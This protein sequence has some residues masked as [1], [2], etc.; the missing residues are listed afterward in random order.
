MEKIQIYVSPTGNDAAAGT[1]EAP[2]ATLT[3]ARNY[4]RKQNCTG[5]ATVTFLEG[6]YSFRETVNFST[7]D[8]GNSENPIVY[9]G[10]GNVIFSGGASISHDHLGEVT[11]AAMA[12]RMPEPEKVKALDLRSLGLDPEK[13]MGAVENTPR[14]YVGKNIADKAYIPARFPNWERVGGRKGPYLSCEKITGFEKEPGAGKDQMRL[15]FHFDD[16]DTARPKLEKWTES[17]LTDAYIY[18]YF[19]HQWVYNRYIPL[20]GDIGEGTLTAA[21]HAD[22]KEVPHSNCYEKLGETTGHRRRLFVSNLPEELDDAG[23]YYYDR[24][25]RIL[26]F[27][28]LDDFTAETEMT[29]SVYDKP[30]VWVQGAENITFRNIRFSY[31]VRHPLQVSESKSIVFDGCEI[32][33]SSGRAAYVEK[34]SDCKFISCDIFDHTTGGILFQSCGDRYNLV[35]SGN[36]VRNCIIQYISEIVPLYKPSVQCID[37]CG[38]TIKGNTI[39]GHAHALII[40]TGVNDIL[41][42]DNLFEEA[43]KDVDDASAVY[44]GRDP[45]DLGI[46][47]RNNFFRNIGNKEATYALSSIYIDDM[48]TGGEIYNNVFYNAAFISDEKMDFLTCPYAMMLNKTQFN[49]AYNNIVVNTYPD[50]KP[51]NLFGEPSFVHWMTSLYDI[52]KSQDVSYDLRGPWYDVLKSQGFL[53]PTWREH[54]RNTHWAGMWDYVNEDIYQR[55]EDYRNAYGPENREKANIDIMWAIYNEMWDHHTEEGEYYSGTFKEYYKER[56][57]EDL[58]DKM[59]DFET[60]LPTDSASTGSHI[61]WKMVYHKLFMRSSNILENNITVGMSRDYLN[62]DGT[63]KGK[64]MNGFRKNYHPVTDKL[65]NGESM[66]VKFGE[67]FDLTVDGL[68]EI[69]KHIPEFHNFSVKNA[70]A[71]R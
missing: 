55:I 57:H 61:F 52:E 49:K 30:G 33:H 66:F 31:F 48:A 26:Y 44:W 18:G 14:F 4:L 53:T 42:E 16:P 8:S 58:K 9:E 7:E 17:A 46:V 12:G 50:Q 19:W 51:C 40:I 38:V 65:E 39:F 1:R 36:E 64:V 54:Y 71:K 45:S 34:S 6:V 22:C 68:K 23:E 3:G 27:I 29:V 21:L 47:V 32:S 5:G 37:C 43:C 25:N 69:H 63:L 28:P 15:C 60:C 70:G 62:A 10:E 24:K 20:Y 13:T 56:Y 2:L 59:E 41:I 67:N 11:D 35:A